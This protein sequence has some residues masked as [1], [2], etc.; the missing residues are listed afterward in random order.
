MPLNFKGLFSPLFPQSD[1]DNLGIGAKGNE[2]ILSIPPAEFR[3]LNPDTDD[4][5]VRTARF[6]TNAAISAVIAPILLPNN[7]TVTKVIVYGNDTG[8][9]WALHRSNYAGTAEDNLASAAINT[10]D[11]TISNAIG[12]IDNENFS[13][14][15][16]IV[17][18]AA[19][20]RIY[21]GVIF[22]T[23]G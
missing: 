21:G 4:V 17:G 11:K 7:A 9:T 3:A 10:A 18:M 6:T 13:Y 14:S 1:R 2:E 20:D 16:N 15:L 23:I 12:I 19:L 22:Y 8:N 5:S